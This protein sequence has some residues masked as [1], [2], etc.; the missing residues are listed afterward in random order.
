MLKLLFSALSLI[1][2]GV[3]LLVVG[4]VLAVLSGM[5]W[6]LGLALFTAV[7]G[8]LGFLFWMVRTAL[9]LMCGILCPRRY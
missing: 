8:A 6:L 9:R 5:A 1:L 4:L 7:F 3:I 2:A